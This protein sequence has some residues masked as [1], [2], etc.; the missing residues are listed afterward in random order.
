M[1]FYTDEQ[2]AN[3]K[4]IIFVGYDSQLEAHA[5][6]LRCAKSG[7]V[8]K[9]S[10]ADYSA[11]LTTSLIKIKT[12][13]VREAGAMDPDLAFD[14]LRQTLLVQLVHDGDSS[15]PLSIK[16]DARAVEVDEALLAQSRIR[17]VEEIA[18]E[19]IAA[20]CDD[21]SLSVI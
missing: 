8:T 19:D 21:D 14:L 17:S 5:I 16:P 9:M 12:L 13:A 4:A 6:D 11:K 18:V 1:C 2:K 10:K 7:H 3:G 15:L 20:L